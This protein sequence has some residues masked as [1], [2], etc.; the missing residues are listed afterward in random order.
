MTLTQLRTFLAIADTGSVHAAARRLYVTQSAVSAALNALQKSLG[1]QLLE[2]EGRGL[3]LTRAGVVYADHVRTALGL[4]DQAHTAA[5]A[6]SDPERGELRIAALTTAGEQI[7]PGV[8]ASFRERHPH[9]G[10]RLEVGNR[11]RVRRLLERHE[12]DLV[13]GGR[14][15]PGREVEVLATRPHELIV[16]ANSPGPGDPAWLAAQ[17][18][19]MREPGSGTR[20][21][22]ESFLA[23]LELDPPPRTLTLGSNTAVIESAL[24]G[25]GITLVSRDAVT[26]HLDDGHL[27]EISTPATPLLRDWHLTANPGPTPPTTALFTTHLTTTAHFHTP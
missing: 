22:T 20:A 9:V 13:L 16:V 5:A 2:R 11:E 17:T 21:I 7:L 26:R 6:E 25:L 15:E 10:V 19:L 27:T 14:P 8:L 1:L 3:R 23:Q 24:A 12:V 18:W 4:L